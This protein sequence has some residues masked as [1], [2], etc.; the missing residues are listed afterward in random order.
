MVDRL[1][2][3]QNVFH[4]FDG[5]INRL[6]SP[7]SKTNHALRFCR[8]WV[9]NLCIYTICQQIRKKGNNLLTTYSLKGPNIVILDICPIWKRAK[10]FARFFDLINM[11]IGNGISFVPIRNFTLPWTNSIGSIRNLNISLTFVSNMAHMR[12]SLLNF[13]ILE[14]PKLWTQTLILWIALWV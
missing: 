10:R 6:T 3:V 11:G 14:N 13:N 7:D 12:V 4:V 2:N 8:T 5:R 9:K 1:Q